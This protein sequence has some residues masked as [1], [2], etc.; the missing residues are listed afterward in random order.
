MAERL[1]VSL[2]RM[3]EL[4]MVEVRQ[5]YRST[6]FRGCLCDKEEEMETGGCMMHY[7]VTRL[8][9]ESKVVC[10]VR[11]EQRRNLHFTSFVIHFTSFIIHF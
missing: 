8:Y 10:G 4:E 11:K 2:N 3:L 6:W 9:G 5:L 7:I 1:A